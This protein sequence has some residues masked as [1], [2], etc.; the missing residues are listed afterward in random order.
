MEAGIPN[1]RNNLNCLRVDRPGIY[2]ML[3]L[4]SK[5]QKKKRDTLFI[6]LTSSVACRAHI[7]FHLQVEH[8]K[9][10]SSGLQ[11]EDTDIQI[12]THYFYFYFMYLS[13]SNDLVFVR[14]TSPSKKY[15]MLLCMTSFF[16][17]G[18][19]CCC[20]CS[21]LVIILISPAILQEKLNIFW[22]QKLIILPNAVSFQQMKH[23][24]WDQYSFIEAATILKL[25]ANVL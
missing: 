17:G 16:K 6:R 18:I 2:S 15:M 8:T 13:R 11:N 20:C 25:T 22:D 5:Y 14:Q 10:K 23:F 19:C 4:K 3:G 12:K 21:F 7:I 24:S 9:R 1:F